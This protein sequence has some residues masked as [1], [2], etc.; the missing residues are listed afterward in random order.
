MACTNE[1]SLD[2]KKTVLIIWFNGFQQI[3]IVIKKKKSIYEI[4]FCIKNFKGDLKDLSPFLSGLA[5]AAR[6]VGAP[7]ASM[8]PRWPSRRFNYKG[9]SIKDVRMF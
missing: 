3:R 8:I 7:T 2:F 4:Q 6:G 9:P 5:A 1:S